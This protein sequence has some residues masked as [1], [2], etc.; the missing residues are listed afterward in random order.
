[1]TPNSTLIQNE[2]VIVGTVSTRNAAE[3]GKLFT[4]SA[5]W[6]A[7]SQI[8]AQ[9]VIDSRSAQGREVSFRS[10]ARRELFSK[11]IPACSKSISSKSIDPR[12]S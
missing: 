4:L 10:F 6:R 8:Y 11:A 9:L 5:N 2:L 1:M 12:C 3:E 7:L